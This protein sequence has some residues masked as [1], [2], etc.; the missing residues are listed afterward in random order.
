MQ[1]DGSW[2][3]EKYSSFLFDGDLLVANVS[4]VIGSSRITEKYAV[5]VI[6][7]ISDLQGV[8]R[9]HGSGQ[10]TGMYIGIVAMTN[11]SG[12]FA[13]IAMQKVPNNIL[14]KVHNI[15]YSIHKSIDSLKLE[16]NNFYYYDSQDTEN[17]TFNAE[18]K[19]VIFSLFPETLQMKKLMILQQIPAII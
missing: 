17:R 1:S 7:D 4:Q 9:L 2:T 12:A 8:Y 11:S 16:N 19:Q 10:Y 5:E 6:K 14:D 13:K 15:H 3:P 18:N